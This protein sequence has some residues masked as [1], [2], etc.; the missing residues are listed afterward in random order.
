MGNTG[1]GNREELF[2]K[3]GKILPS[4]AKNWYYW[5]YINY[6]EG[7]L[8]RNNAPWNNP[9][10]LQ[11]LQKE[12]G[13]VPDND[14]GK[15][16]RWK[17]IQKG[18]L[19]AVK[20]NHNYQQYHSPWEIH[21]ENIV[22]NSL[23]AKNIIDKTCNI[24]NE[25]NLKE[26]E[27][28]ETCKF[29]TEHNLCLPERRNK[30]YVKGIESNIK[31]IETLIKVMPTSE[32]IP[33][34]FLGIMSNSLGIKADTEIKH[35][36]SRG[37]S[38]ETIC[39][40]M[41]RNFADYEDIFNG[42][43]IVPY[44]YSRQIQCKLENIRTHLKKI[45]ND[46]KY[47]G[48]W[49][50]NFRDPILKKMKSLL[51]ENGKPCEVFNASETE[52]Q[53][54]RF[55]E[56]WFEDF[57]KKKQNIQNNIIHRCVNKHTKLIQLRDGG[58]HEMACEA[59][60]NGYITFL[61]S[62][63]F[64]YDRYL[65]KC[66]DNIMKS[67]N[68]N[69]ENNGEYIATTEINT[70]L[71]KI[72]KKLK[73]PDS[74]CKSGH[75]V[76]LL[77][78]FVPSDANF[79][80]HRGY[81][82]GCQNNSGK[83]NY[84]RFFNNGGHNTN[85]ETILNELRACTM[86][87]DD[88]D[89]SVG[90]NG[91]K[92]VTKSG[93][94]KS[95]CGVDYN[96][97]FIRK[98]TSNPCWNN[99]IEGK[100]WICDRARGGGE[101]LMSDWT[102]KACMPPRTQVLCLG[103]LHADNTGKTY[104]YI[105]YID[106]SQK[107]LTEMLV[108]AK[109]EGENLK[110]YFASRHKQNGG[111]NHLCNAM[112][113]SFSDLGDVVRGRSIWGNIYTQW[114]ENNL[115]A[116]FHKIYDKLPNEKKSI[117][118]DSTKNYYYLR[119]TWWNTNREYIWKA[120]SCGAKIIDDGCDGAVA[121]NIDYMPQFLRWLTEWSGHFCEGKDAY[122]KPYPNPT[123]E[124]EDKNI[125]SMCK[126]CNA[127][128]GGDC[129]NSYP[130]SGH[131]SSN[132]S[133][134]K[135]AII[136][137]QYKDWIIDQEGKYNKQKEKYDNEIKNVQ[138]KNSTS[139]PR[140]QGRSAYGINDQSVT[141][142]FKKIEKDYPNVNKFLI[143][144]SKHNGCDKN[145]EKIDFIDE[146]NTFNSKHKHCRGCNEQEHLNI[147]TR[148][149]MLEDGMPGLLPGYPASPT[150]EQGGNRVSGGTKSG[151]TQTHDKTSVTTT[152]HVSSIKSECDDAYSGTWNVW[153]C[154]QKD[155]YKKHSVCKL[156]TSTTSGEKNNDDDFESLF[157]KWVD[158]FL[159]EHTNFKS[160][161]KDCKE[162]SITKENKCPSHDCPLKCYCYNKWLN[163]RKKEWEMQKKYYDDYNNR[164]FKNVGLDYLYKLDVYLMFRFENELRDALGRGT[165][166]NELQEMLENSDAVTQILL[167]S[168]N[169]I[170][171]C[172]G[173]CP[174]AL[175]CN[176]KGFK[177]EWD[178]DKSITTAN[179]GGSSTETEICLKIGDNKYGQANMDMV[180][181]VYK[182]YDSF[183]EWIDYMEKS[184]NDKMKIL[185]QTCHNINTSRRGSDNTMDCEMCTE[186]C[187]CYE[188][189]KKRIDEQWKKLQEYYEGYKNNSNSGITSGNPMKD[190]ELNVFLEAL[191][192]TKYSDTSG[193]GEEIC[194]KL[195][196]DK[197]NF[198]QGLLDKNKDKKNS[199][200]EV[201]DTKH[202]QEETI[203][204]HKCSKIS[205]LYKTK[206]DSKPIYGLKS[207]GI[208]EKTW[209]CDVNVD[210][211]A[212]VPPRGQSIC[213]ASMVHGKGQIVKNEF[214][215]QEHLKNKLKSAIKRETQRLHEIYTKNENGIRS[216]STPSITGEMPLG[217]C[218]A[219]H[220]S[221]NDYKHMVLGD[222]L[223][224]FINIKN[225]QEKIGTLISKSGTHATT[226]ERRAWWKSNEKELWNA[227]KCGIKDA[228]NDLNGNECPRL[229]ND[230]DQLEWWAKEWSEDFYKKRNI[231]VKEVEEKCGNGSNGCSTT[232]T[233][234]DVQCKSE[235]DKYKRFL[236]LKR[237]Q[238]TN[239]FKKFLDDQQEKQKTK[240]NKNSY[241]EEKTYM[242]QNHY[243]LYPC[244]Y[245]S[246]DGT[247]I[248]DLLGKNEHGQYEKECTCGTSQTSGKTVET[249]HCDN[250]YEYHACNDKKFSN[251]IWSSIYV[252]NPK[253]R[254]KVYA[255][256]RRN[257]IC[258]GWLFSPIEINANQG[259]NAKEELKKKVI[260]AARGEAHYLWKYYN[261]KNS[262][263]SGTEPPHGYCDALKRS[264]A[265]IG[266]MVKGTDLW[267]AGYSPLVEQNIQSVFQ[268]DNDGTGSKL[269][270]TKEEL[271][272]E[273]KKWWEKIRT[274]VWNAMNCDN[275]KCGD[276]TIPSDDKKPQFLRWLEEWGEYICEE[277]K[278]H[279]KEL[280][281]KC[282]DGNNS[283]ENDK[284]CDR[285]NEACKKQCNKYN[286]WINTHKNE[287]LG[288]K[289][290]YEE[291]VSDKFDDKYDE[292]KRHIKDHVDANTY[293]KENCDKYK[294][295]TTNVNM[296][297]IF[298]KTDDDYKEYEPFCT[299]CRIN[300]IAE[301]AKESKRVNPCGD[302]RAV[303]PTKNVKEVAE[304]M[305]GK[306]KTLMET[307]SV[308]IS[309]P[310][311]VLKGD[312]SKAEFKGGNA[313]NLNNG[314]FCKL[315]KKKHT[316]DKRGETQ[317]PDGPCQ[318]KGGRLKDRFK[319]GKEWVPKD[320]EVKVGHEGVLLPPR[321]LDMCTSNLE[322]LYTEYK[323][324]N[325]GNKAIHSLLGDVLLAAKMEGEFI[326]NNYNGQN[327][328]NDKE[329]ICR[330][331]KYSFADIGD[332]MRGRDLWNREY[333]NKNLQ[334]HLEKIFGNINKNLLTTGINIY[335]DAEGKYLK[336][337][338][339]WWEAN[340]DQVWEAM[341]CAK[342]N[343]GTPPCRG[344]HMPPF[345]DYIPQRLRWMTEWAEWYCKIQSQ[346]YGEVMKGCGSCKNNTKTGEKCSQDGDCKKCKDVCGKYQTFITKWRPQWEKMKQKYEELY[347]EAESG[348]TTSTDKDVVDFLT[349]LHQ[350]NNGKSTTYE[351]AA[352]YVHEELKNMECHT[353]K[354][355]CDKPILDGKSSSDN[356][357]YA[358]KDKP[359]DH[360]AACSCNNDNAAQKPDSLK[361]QAAKPAATKPD[362][363]RT[364]EAKPASTQST[365]GGA[366][367][368][369]SV[370][371]GG[372]SNSQVIT[373]SETTRDG[374]GKIEIT[375]T[376]ANPDPSSEPG[377]G[378]GSSTQPGGQTSNVDPR[379]TKSQTPSQK[380][381]TSKDVCEIVKDVLSI[382][383]NITTGGIENCNPKTE[384]FNWDCDPESMNDENK[385]AC[386]PPRRQKL[387]IHNL[388]QLKTSSSKEDL[389]ESFIKC[390]ALETHFLWNKYKGENFQEISQLQA[391]TIPDKFK[392]QMFYTYSDYRDLCL[393]KDIGKLNGDVEK[394]RTKINNILKP[395]SQP[396]SQS[397]EDWWEINGPDIWKGMVCALSHTGGD[398]DKLTTNNDYNNV[399]FYG[400]TI[401]LSQF[402]TRPQFLRWF[403]EWSDEFCHER[404]TQLM[405]LKGKCS[406]YECNKGRNEDKKTKCEG[407]CEIYQ[408]FIN[409]W[410]KEY[411]TQSEK[412]KTD[413]EGNAFEKTTAKDDVDK[414]NHAYQYLNT[415]L[416]KLCQNGQCMCM[417][418][419][420][421]KTKTSQTN[422]IDK[423]VMPKSLDYPPEEF[424]NSCDCKPPKEEEPDS[425][426]NCVDK[427][428]FVLKNVSQEGIKDVEKTLKGKNTK[429]VY[430][431]KQKDTDYGPI[432]KIKENNGQIDICKYNGNPFDD[433]D[434]WECKNRTIKVVNEN[435]CFPPRR[436]HMCTEPL[437][438]LESTS[439][440][441]AEELFIKVL[442]TAANEGKHLK[443]QWEKTKN[444]PK[445]SDGTTR[446][447][448]KRYELCDAMKYSFADLGDIIRGRDN[449][450]GINGTNGLETKLNGV[451]EK[452][453][454]QWENENGG[455][456][457]DKYKNVTSFRSAWWDTNR[458]SIWKAMT[459]SAPDNFLIL[460]SGKGG[461]SDIE[462]LTSSEH[463][464]C[465]HKHFPPN[466]DYIPQP[467]RWISEW[468]ENYCLSQNHKLSI[469]KD[470]DNCTINNGKCQQKV[471]E[472]CKKCKN[473][474]E[475][476][477][478]FVEN[479]KTQYEL[480]EE[481]YEN[482]YNKGIENIS[483]ASAGMNAND[484]HIKNFV[485]ELETNCK[486]YKQNSSAAIDTAN[487]V[488][489]YLDKGNYCKKFKFSTTSNQDA[490]Y[491]FET[492]AYIYKENCECATKFQEV[493]QCPVEKE[494][495]ALYGIYSC[496]KKPSNKN[497]IEWNNYLVNYNSNKNKAVMVPPRR[498]ELCLANLRNLY[499][500]R[501]NNT[502]D[503]MEYILHTAYSEANYLWNIHKNDEQKALE[504]MKYSFADIGNIV[505][506]NDMLGDGVSE[507]I[508]YIFD[509]K[510][511]KKNYSLSSNP[512]ITRIDWWEK[513]KEKIWNVMMCN[514][515]GNDK[516]L[517]SCPSHGNIDRENQFLRWMT[518]WAKY[519]CKEKIEQLKDLIQRC[520][521][522]AES[523]TYNSIYEIE[524]GPCKELL[525][526]YNY[527]FHN[528]DIEWKD[529]SEKYT[530]YYKSQF[531]SSFMSSTADEYLK[532]K[533][534][535]CNCNF[536]DIIELYK[537]N[538]KG[539]GI[540]DSIIEKKENTP[541]KR[542][543][544]EDD[545][546]AVIPTPN[547]PAQDTSI[548][549][550]D[551]TEPPTPIE[552]PKNDSSHYIL[553]TTIP[554][555]VAVAL[556][557]IAFL[558]LKKKPKIPTTKLFRVIDIPQNDYGIPNKTSTNRY[559]PYRSAQY[560]GK[561]YIYVEGEETDDYS[562]LRDICSSDITSSSESEYEDMDINDI[563]PYKSPKY[564]TLI[565]VVLKPSSK[566]Y[567]D[568]SMYQKDDTNKLT[569][570]EW[571]QLKQDFI[572]QYLQNIQKDL[573][574]E[575]FVDDNIHKDIQPNILDVS[576]DEKPFITSIQDR[577]L[578]SSGQEVSYN[579][580]WNIP[581]QNEITN[582]TLDDPKY[583]SSNLY[584]GI[585]L[586][587][588]SLCGNQN[589]V[590]IYDELIKRKENELFG[591]KYTKNTTFNRV[592]KETH[593][594]P[595]LNQ[596][597][598]FHKW[599]DRHRDM[600]NQWN[601]KE[602]M[603]NK[604]N[605]EWEKENNINYHIINNT[606]NDI[607]NN[608]NNKSKLSNANVFMEI[609]MD[610]FNVTNTDVLNANIS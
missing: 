302:K 286:R 142:F 307:N 120:L 426:L 108:A 538:E 456:H 604:L 294:S 472:S 14:N 237:D 586:I 317:R 39:K 515:H 220:R 83:N 162:N 431:L 301:R 169:L 184:I 138:N 530:K 182:F 90:G 331:M 236:T 453:R 311:N 92:V 244:T 560:K 279:M 122:D 555:G 249:K 601:N 183:E 86:N 511:N 402:A 46:E 506:G 463:T 277:K 324:L 435:I 82:C 521:K 230:D 224:K 415:Q 48:L 512:K 489:K 206:C 145:V 516:T 200:C 299:T 21:A 561:T 479:W 113:Y 32:V 69:E 309:T 75:E 376:Q 589:V 72:K 28:S 276:T 126:G 167:N 275:N 603:L 38:E 79:S 214:S 16:C 281:K 258:I 103:Y 573:A 51:D 587:D 310:K 181:D 195:K 484:S 202:I 346:V 517:I 190:I 26:K 518:E 321:R 556:T 105:D 174:K 64:C 172:V 29:N 131:I 296:D 107:L 315:D 59:Y 156:Q 554:F 234:P 367:G 186:D 154:E 189:W 491:A 53:C 44:K 557:S 49:N 259:G 260:D 77:P 533:C 265:D 514:Y 171:E 330:A 464:N 128:R 448:I 96:D 352:G 323:G 350:A 97:S 344:D 282:N 424:K 507:R 579:I 486:T 312:I 570:N 133:C 469:F 58:K 151:D 348:K 17:E 404:K 285:G 393:G 40:I 383:R 410:K 56:E 47:N 559:V 413:K 165:S 305:Q 595:I 500:A 6:L 377:G 225:L 166:L 374:Q 71:K 590:D 445:T 391:G 458:V 159:K 117:Y 414:A 372:D 371:R 373:I 459:C 434:K 27:H 440:T 304:E 87:D 240:Q 575:N 567:D 609:H 545:T 407:A 85:L 551:V 267:M 37:I 513:N 127:Q 524:Q 490:D 572:S 568:T 379:S 198:V 438:N 155:K 261:K 24:Y 217:F 204:P 342:I 333:G 457:K 449:Y 262:G 141:E 239:N 243:L 129:L 297:A 303:K 492:P 495:C 289:S 153:D 109:Y 60:C 268:L 30:L 606:S 364:Q 10:F 446:P 254:G 222:S 563:Y 355:F 487:S 405:L 68:N 552:P 192:E 553:A 526:K 419:V 608:I 114:M 411:E 363:P 528:K 106:T 475:E 7:E 343:G 98:Y 67:T 270:K 124:N 197:K 503:F 219:V 418:K 25:N 494:H 226:E 531:K 33:A 544:D 505:K 335:N 283:V 525:K 218:D 341:K 18:I 178:C 284:T 340:R 150:P 542:I 329:G 116:I 406:D 295:G 314:E 1:S 388:T 562:Y 522:D 31:S 390:A 43:D 529:L 417:E 123:S 483:K 41:K 384:P 101:R 508:E 194:K 173:I 584:S 362:V 421:T 23:H 403:V 250:S 349:Q 357:E 256:P 356:K 306:A 152:T 210:K 441:T 400:S 298:N 369:G 334:G 326:K 271:L 337:R 409:K 4:G 325:D 462:F 287:W 320:G 203:D 5:N 485:E 263:T 380:D 569:D 422:S 205:Y 8:K 482:I 394:A 408:T 119:E 444:N 273:R 104:N 88:L 546:Q 76:D 139:L 132:D 338:N 588:D 65:R 471:R 454:T 252:K 592:S 332:I 397:A 232:K 450:K 175:T 140:T 598:L 585:D 540:I 345:D 461:G 468:S 247:H 353:Q 191:C 550:N 95:I 465:G 319:I 290:K 211:N 55:L 50:R 543:T 574:N 61:E 147:L 361:P 365:S 280:K 180:K 143:D 548:S 15:F 136:C 600:C 328:Q 392:S 423:D 70:M 466:D 509:E 215:S 420:S 504:A 541:R 527:W 3:Y 416:K 188:K 99:K 199:V 360:D 316:N 375:T 480:L 161:I 300:D 389:R 596:I 63:K 395:N 111:D 593:S 447:S 94:V 146:T 185:K 209:I 581:K 580:N 359:H 201:C 571:Y 118:N 102:N 84:K 233:T 231:L 474:C 565:E 253:D 583:V 248:K 578:G 428:A 539:D 223:W 66:K 2:E 177:N 535:D 427:S 89:G 452:I 385:G 73:C 339:D 196:G 378:I 460:K 439:I 22:R 366:S 478:K 272:E 437:E 221:F 534:P 473:T 57:L 358:F 80:L 370:A 91:E 54:L 227:A 564:K 558:F 274:E 245:Q 135:C 81:H 597:D 537:K 20:E 318:G 429:D 242:P 510:I 347:K 193:S 566:T 576:N 112:K 100:G 134:S 519:F 549:K 238:W 488:D 52:P 34:S 501:I 477:N 594:D 532:E 11:I 179:G 499:R 496:R 470:C 62:H 368:H 442:R 229:I 547:P 9:K 170:D 257:S 187:G 291:I 148:G 476:Y 520:Q 157:N 264:F 292:F 235:C 74:I 401:T 322:N 398:K 207:N 381:E 451:F 137:K 246:C 144:R 42:N 591:T 158:L 12:N 255:P 313:S 536:K 436:K 208:E 308:K 149:N 45:V 497:P 443:E 412:Y 455:K 433:I 467:F 582:N 212:C 19:E 36:K 168:E 266:D 354:Y 278:K 241:D 602:E 164:T 125:E 481:A 502:N 607:I 213:I 523:T 293:I 577:F 432:C 121:P 110:K 13:D 386:M 493:D 163:R 605:E 336:L 160:K 228:N 93:S 610:Q 78:Y 35:L 382:P 216:E 425:S 396:S 130:M 399:T 176:E 351:N 430:E 498:R 288:Q 387:C 251:N 269:I 115:K 327:G 599:L